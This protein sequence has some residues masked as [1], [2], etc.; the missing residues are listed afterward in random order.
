MFSFLLL[1]FQ[2][3]Y[4]LISIAFSAL[5]LLVGPQEADTT[6]TP[7]SLASYKSRFVW[8]FWYRLTQVVLEKRP[9]N[10]C[11]SLPSNKSFRKPPSL[12]TCPSQ[13]YFWRQML[14][15]MLLVSLTLY[16]TSTSVTLSFQLTHS[17]LLP[18]HTSKASNLFLL[19]NDNVEVSAACNH[20]AYGTFCNS[21]L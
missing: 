7:S 1:V 13:L 19:A 18:I 3:F 21:C 6:A 17:I 5:T 14:S 10:G 2:S 9:L 4:L 8:P 16:S 20:V 12:R 11:L 15:K